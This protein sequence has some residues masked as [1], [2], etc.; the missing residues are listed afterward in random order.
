MSEK[1]NEMFSNIADRYDRM[2]HILS[3]GIDTKWRADAVRQIVDR[4]GTGRKVRV[5]DVATGTGDLAIVLS[6]SLT[7]AGVDAEI[8]GIDFNKDM[9]K[10]GEEKADKAACRN[11][12]FRLGDALRIKCESGYFDIV[13]S[14][15][16]LRNFDDLE[17]FSREMYRVLKR[18]GSFML[19]DMAMPRKGGERAFFAVYSYYMRFLGLFVNNNAYKWLVNSIKAFDKDRLASILRKTGFKNVRER[20][21]ATGVAYIMSG[22]K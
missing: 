14:G 12:R 22:Q 4:L 10:L 15:F 7:D 13:I 9:L 5:L 1:L 20:E 3:F 19:L 18:N 11:I 16:A 21:L 2:N 6:K 8:V 17:L